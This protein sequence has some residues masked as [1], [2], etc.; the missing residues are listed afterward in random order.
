MPSDRSRR[1]TVRGMLITGV[2]SPLNWD[3]ETRSD[4]NDDPHTSTGA[5][6]GEGPLGLPCGSPRPLT[7][8]SQTQ[9]PSSKKSHR[10][11]TK[12]GGGVCPFLAGFYAV[13]SAARSAPPETLDPRVTL[14]PP[15]QRLL[16]AAPWFSVSRLLVTGALSPQMGQLT[17][18]PQ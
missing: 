12:A 8:P 14:R 5:E 15:L 4:L 6:G 16:P 18:R 13:S 10:S 3:P 11:W 2:S 9:A 17:L 1:R 7:T